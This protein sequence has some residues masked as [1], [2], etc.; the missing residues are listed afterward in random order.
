MT[1]EI[2]EDEYWINI[3]RDDVNLINLNYI[4]MPIHQTDWHN[5]TYRVDLNASDENHIFSFYGRNGIGKTTL[6]SKINES[7][8]VRHENLRKTL[9]KKD[10]KIF[11]MKERM[12]SDFNS[13]CPMLN[14]EINQLLFFHQYFS[15]NNIGILL[16]SINFLT[17]PY[18]KNIRDFY[19]KNNIDKISEKITYLAGINKISIN[20]L[21]YKNQN[22]IYIFV[23]ELEN[24]LNEK[25][26]NILFFLENRNF[27]INSN[28]ILS[29]L[30][31]Y[32]NVE[33]IVV[34]LIECLN[35]LENHKF[36]FKEKNL[37]N[38]EII[39]NLLFLKSEFELLA[40]DFLEGIVIKEKYNSFLESNYSE[41]FIV[42]R[43]NKPI[44]LHEFIKKT[45]EGQNKLIRLFL[46]L[47]EVRAFCNKQ[48][49]VIAD[50]ILDSFDNKNV[51]HIMS[52]IKK[53]IEKEKPTFLSFTHDFEIFRIINEELNVNRE[54]AYLIVRNNQK[55][56][57]EKLYISKGNLEEYIQE[58][59]KNKNS[60]EL[61]T[62]RFLISA[63]C[64][65]DDIK[66]IL[67][68]NNNIY[69]KITSLLHIKDDSLQ[70]LKDATHFS[71]LFFF[72]RFT[73]HLKRIE[74]YANEHINY[75]DL[76]DSIFKYISL[77][78]VKDLEKNIFL[79]IY[80]RILIERKILDEL[81]SKYSCT[82]KEILE[83]IKIN[84]TNGLIEYYLTKT[85]KNVP[86]SIIL[87]YEYL[88][89]FIHISR[90]LSYLINIDN[91]M[92]LRLIEN[93]QV[94][95]FE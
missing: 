63:A 78:K 84:Q 54:N 4:N 53:A 49:I 35:K 93:V 9:E 69:I 26:I 79:A 16:S 68:H 85:T 71:E 24:Y 12:N 13:I 89:K 38:N 64:V 5:I 36:L 46:L 48:T 18:D 52:L 15:H 31:D 32:D 22:S 72:Q 41:I 67:G 83:G 2:L 87:L 75:Y 19:I 57:T 62:L 20:D 3:I 11:R 80:A 73:K 14:N 28:N 17:N 82:E 81:S 70:I 61:N 29:I 59:L 23:K 91:V 39:K 37:E 1:R 47:S 95:S 90:G 34:F 25:G 88:K 77:N 94:E 50:D 51:I 44:K 27:S 65:R 66:R 8:L 7:E 33:E 30:N 86:D 60:D 40:H 74:I 56:S 42:N 21:K 58:D 45:S 76:L 55:I 43:K 10:T 92:L 6:C